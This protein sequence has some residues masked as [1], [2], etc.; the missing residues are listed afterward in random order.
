VRIDG[1]SAWRNYAAETEFFVPGHSGFDIAV[2]SGIAE[3]V[4]SFE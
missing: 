1:E 4:C 2:E 3:Y